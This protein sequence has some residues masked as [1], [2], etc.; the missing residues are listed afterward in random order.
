ME[1]FAIGAL[2][3]IEHFLT[4]L[5]QI[6]Y[7]E[8]SQKINVFFLEKFIELNEIYEQAR[9]VCDNLKRKT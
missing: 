1:I 4:K 3:I 2:N 6:N 8:E 7:R 9:I 5:R